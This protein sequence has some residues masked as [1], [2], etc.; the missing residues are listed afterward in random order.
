MSS[1]ARRYVLFNPCVHTTILG[2]RKPEYIEDIVE[3][4]ELGLLPEDLVSSLKEAHDTDFGLKGE[5]HLGFE[6]ALFAN[7]TA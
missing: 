5:S 6:V 4:L 7:K 3:D 2:V 1:L